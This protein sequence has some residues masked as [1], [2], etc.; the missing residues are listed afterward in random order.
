V[1]DLEEARAIVEGIIRDGHRAGDVIRR[2]RALS[3]NTAPQK[4]WLDLNAVIHEVVALI[5]SELHQHSVSLLTD[6]SATLP[7]VLGDRVHQQV[8]LNLLMNGIEAMHAV[9]DRPRSYRS[10]RRGRYLT[11]CSSTGAIDWRTFQPLLE[12]CVLSSPNS[13]HAAIIHNLR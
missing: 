6:L 8:L 13:V 4:A 11:P 3:Q 1:S 9:T 12:S 7:L 5:H 2:I 10:G